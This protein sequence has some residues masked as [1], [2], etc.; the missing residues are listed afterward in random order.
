MSDFFEVLEPGV[1][2]IVYADDTYLYA[3]G[4][5]YEDVI[6]KLQNILLNA[7]TLGKYGNLRFNA[8]KSAIIHVS[9]KRFKPDDTVY[10]GGQ[11]I[12]WIDFIKILD[13]NFSNN[14]TWNSHVAEIRQETLRKLNVSKCIPAHIEVSPPEISCISPS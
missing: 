5:L 12:L 2:R 8:S 4:S 11:P 13:L 1:D 10:I 3:S 14:S 6:Q 9:K 7:A